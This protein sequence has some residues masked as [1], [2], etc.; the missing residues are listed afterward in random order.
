MKRWYI[1]LLIAL[2]ACSCS[3]K[4]VEPIEDKIES[5]YYANEVLTVKLESDREIL[6]EVEPGQEIYFFDL[7]GK[8]E[9]LVFF[10]D[11]GVP[12]VVCN[13]LFYYL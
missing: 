8:V 9:Q 6:V 3:P 1:S 11:Y 12:V 13:G 5:F 4:T 7:N 10:Y 2:M